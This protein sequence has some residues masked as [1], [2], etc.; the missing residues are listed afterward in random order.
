MLN[1]NQKTIGYAIKAEEILRERCS[2]D[3]K[4][5]WLLSEIKRYGD[6]TDRRIIQGESV[7][8][9]QEVVSIVEDHTDIIVKGSRETH[10][11]HKICYTGGASN[12]ILDCVILESNPADIDLV[13]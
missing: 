11:D 5:L 2:A 10:Y 3:L 7:P 9:D 6:L 4:L 12:L 8:A 1:M 13:E